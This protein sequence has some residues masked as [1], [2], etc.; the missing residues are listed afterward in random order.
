M[1][2]HPPLKQRVVS[3]MISSTCS[4][5]DLLKQRPKN[6][7]EINMQKAMAA[8]DQGDSLCHT[9]ERFGVPRSTLH[10]HVTGKVQLGAMPGPIPYLTM[11]EEEQ[12]VNFLVRCSEIG[13]AHT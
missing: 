8:V 5:Q 2:G 11:E 12:L 6:Y 9:A 3:E 13:Y 10:D 4:G 1:Y 7:N